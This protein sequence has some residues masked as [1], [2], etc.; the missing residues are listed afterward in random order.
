MASWRFVF[1]GVLLAMVYFL[2]ATQ[3]FPR[4]N[5][6]CRDLDEHYWSHKRIVAGG[7]LFVN[8]V[9]TGALLTRAAPAWD[10]WW[11]YFYFPSYM[12]AIAG[13]VFSRSRSLDFFFL[14][15][16]LLVNVSAGSDLVP[17]SQFARTTGIVASY[18]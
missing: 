10:D 2:A 3:T 9:V 12:A 5:A 14:G 11:F 18:D 17:H 8:V 1:T 4:G 7:I 16:A 6:E 13:L 15:W